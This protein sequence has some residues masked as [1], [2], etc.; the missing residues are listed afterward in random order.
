MPRRTYRVSIPVTIDLEVESTLDEEATLAAV[1]DAFSPGRDD[2]LLGT[3]IRNVPNRSWAL[4]GN[5]VMARTCGAVHSGP[6]TRIEKD[7]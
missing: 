7:A 4:S 2:P 5:F 3:M 6:A 1:M